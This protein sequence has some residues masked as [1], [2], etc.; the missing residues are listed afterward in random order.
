[1]EAK[2]IENA[3]IIMNDID[4]V[5]KVQDL[6]E[7]K[8]GDIKKFNYDE[9]N[10]NLCIEANSWNKRLYLDGFKRSAFDYALFEAKDII[11]KL[12][13]NYLIKELSIRKDKI[14]NDMLDFMVSMK[15]KTEL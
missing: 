14:Q 4:D 7:R 8:K 5:V 13:Q 3:N 2:L 1:M 12:M 10:P 11:L 9:G 6:L 15:N